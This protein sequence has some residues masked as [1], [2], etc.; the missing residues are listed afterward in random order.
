MNRKDYKK[1]MDKIEPDEGMKYRII[2]GIKKSDKKTSL[3]RGGKRKMYF[4]TSLAMMIC[5]SLVISLTWNEVKIPTISQTN[6]PNDEK[7]PPV[8]IPKIEPP[9]KSSET[10]LM[11]PLIVYKGN[12]YIQNGAQLFSDIAKNLQGDK[13]GR[14]KDVHSEYDYIHRSDYIELAS[15]I[16]EVDIFSVEG[17]DSDF[18]IMSY[19]EIDGQIEAKMFEHL[20]G[21]TITKGEDLMGKLKMKDQIE[22][23]KWQ[24]YKRWNMGKAKMNKLSSDSDQQVEDFIDALYAAKPVAEKPLYKKGINRTEQKWLYFKLKDQTEVQLRLFKE[25]NY[26]SYSRAPV[27]LQVD[28]EVFDAL[29]EQM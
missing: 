26:V 11:L 15:T 7:Y 9:E 21:I 27:F 12:V 2:Q 19:Q 22:S 3:T 1:M 14:T 10:A 6:L 5:V 16:G 28:S 25:G 4:V 29:W 23:V 13:L 8:V 17:Y 20:D 24:D 18:R